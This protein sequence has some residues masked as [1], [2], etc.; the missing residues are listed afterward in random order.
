MELEINIKLTNGADSESAPLI[1]HSRFN[2]NA[3]VSDSKLYERILADTLDSIKEH[4]S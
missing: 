1:V 3:E 2:Y 4:G